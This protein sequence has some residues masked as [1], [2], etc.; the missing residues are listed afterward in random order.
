MNKPSILS[1]ISHSR[2]SIE[3]ARISSLV[4]SLLRFFSHPFQFLV[5][6]CPTHRTPP[7]ERRAELQIPRRLASGANPA[8]PISDKQI[9]RRGLALVLPRFSIFRV[10][11]HLREAS[12]YCVPSAEW[13]LLANSP[14]KEL[15]RF[16]RPNLKNLPGGD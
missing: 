12:F 6:P 3:S 8:A 11:R 10:G 7:D 4:I 15:M 1:A 14:N 13:I 5:K 2:S 16:I 9:Q